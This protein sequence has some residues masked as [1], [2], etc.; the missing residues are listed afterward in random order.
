MK[1]ARGKW[2]VRTKNYGDNMCSW[3][4]TENTY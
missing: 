1:E 2:L 4:L 3:I